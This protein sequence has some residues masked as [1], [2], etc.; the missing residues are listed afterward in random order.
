MQDDLII[1][2]AKNGDVQAF[3]ELISAYERRIFNTALRTMKNPDDAN[4]VAQEAIIKIYK[5]IAGFKGDCTFAV[6]VYRIVSNACYDELRRRK[7]H[8]DMSLDALTAD[9]VVQFRDSGELPDQY[10]ERN[11]LSQNIQKAINQLDE[12][13]R[14]PIVLRELQGLSYQEIADIMDVNLGTVKS[15][16]SRARLQLQ[17]KLRAY[18]Q[19]P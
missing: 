1:E 8:S 15:R 5:N 14:V 11:E 12:E 4:D 19:N 10:A 7:R 3:E 9:G 16:I 2:R 13:Y 17:K 18:L 6:W